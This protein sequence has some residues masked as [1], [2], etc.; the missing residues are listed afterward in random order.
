MRKSWKIPRG[1]DFRGK[2]QKQ[3]MISRW[4]LLLLILKKKRD[5]ENKTYPPDYFFRVMRKKD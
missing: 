4:R 2:E 3:L 1:F 5:Y